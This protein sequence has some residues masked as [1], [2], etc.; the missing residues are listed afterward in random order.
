MQMAIR[1]ILT[2]TR[3]DEGHIA[4]E[5][6]PSDRLEDDLRFDV[7]SLFKRRHLDFHYEL[8]ILSP[9]ID[10]R[11]LIVTLVSSL[12]F[13]APKNSSLFFSL[14]A[15]EDLV[16]L[17]WISTTVVPDWQTIASTDLKQSEDPIYNFIL[18]FTHKRKT[19]FHL[20]QDRDGDT[21]RLTFSRVG[22]IP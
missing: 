5:A 12:G 4:L 18:N 21:L 17:E 3:L 19:N 9:L 8:E 6:I 2:S 14:T 1:A 11:K 7:K 16:I 22:P 13:L 15:E 10:D 20:T